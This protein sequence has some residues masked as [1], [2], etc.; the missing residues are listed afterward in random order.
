MVGAFYENLNEI[1]KAV[2]SSHHDIEI[3]EQPRGLFQHLEWCDLLI[4]AGGTTLFEACAMGAPSIGVSIWP[5]QRP[6]V[7][8]VAS[9]GAAL[10]IN[11]ESSEEFSAQLKEHV[12]KL[13]NSPPLLTQMS[14]AG[15]KFVD[16]QGAKRI[17]FWLQQV[18]N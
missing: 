12:S 10:E 8:S 11:F 9:I 14:R 5:L 18:V 16:G 3:I 13:K 6:A 2:E 7:R 4:S 17:A 15:Q 1:G